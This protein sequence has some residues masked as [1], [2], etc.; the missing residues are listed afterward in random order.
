MFFGTIESVEATGDGTE[1]VKVT[2]DT[3]IKGQINSNSLTL[4]NIPYKGDCVSSAEFI[5]GLSFLGY[6]DSVNLP[7]HLHELGFYTVSCG[8]GLRGYL[9]RSGSLVRLSSVT[10]D[11]SYDLTIMDK[12]TTAVFLF[13]SDKLFGTP[14]KE[15][16][17]FRNSYNIIESADQYYSIT[18]KKLHKIRTNSVIIVASNKRKNPFSKVL[19][20]EN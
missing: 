7:V 8:S 6:I 20:L 11:T 17:K 1:T 18:G 10:I 19:N 2:I 15:K 3:V 9:Y 13:D 5:K 14:V 16:V 4:I 12:C